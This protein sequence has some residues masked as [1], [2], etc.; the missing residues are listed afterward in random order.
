MEAMT[1][2]Q[3][4]RKP[5]LGA[6]AIGGGVILVAQAIA[7]AVTEQSSR[8]SGTTGDVLSDGLLAA[9]LLL[10]LGGLELA[11]RTLAPST[12]A[13]AIAGQA[14]IVVAIAAT[15]VA[16]REVLDA[17]YIIGAVAWLVGSIGIAFAAWRSADRRWRPAVALPIAAL[18]ALGLADVGGPVLLGL[19]WLVLGTRFRRP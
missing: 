9:G 6:L 18:A 5:G 3:E 10:A 11:R 14:A 4:R 2:G 19:I 8:Y 16:G 15:V 13:L 12:G 7:A 17:V 1:I